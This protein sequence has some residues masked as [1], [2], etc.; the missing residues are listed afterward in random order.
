MIFLDL[1]IALSVTVLLGLVVYSQQLEQI[2]KYKM[3]KKTHQKK[4]H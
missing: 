2:E 1:L 4:N 3:R